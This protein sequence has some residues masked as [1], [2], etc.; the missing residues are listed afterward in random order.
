MIRSGAQHGRLDPRSAD[1]YGSRAVAE[2]LADR[3]VSTRVVTTLD[4]ARSRGRPRHHPPGRRPG[5]AD[6]PPADPPARGDRELRRPHRPR[7]PRRPRPSS[8][9]APGV[10][11]DPALSLDSTLAPG[12][13]LPAARRAGSADTG[14]IR[15]TTA[16]LRR[17]HVLPQRTACPPCVRVPA[18]VRERRHRRPRRPRHPP[19]RPPRRA[20]QRLPRPPTPRLPPPSGLVP[21]LARPTTRPPTPG[22]RS[23]FDLLPS[24]W[25]WGTLQLFIAAALAALW[26]ARRLGPLVPED[27]PWRSA[28]PKPSKAAPAST[29]RPTP[30]TARPPLFAP[31]PAPASPP[32]SASP[33]PRRTR[34]RPC[35][36]P[37]PPTSHGDGQALHAL[38]FGPPPGDDAALIALADQLDALE[39][40]V[41]R[42]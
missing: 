35:S 22:D 33:S 23:F 36:P 9:L 24:G 42:P 31:P 12:C 37:C 11:A 34:P 10:T 20:G 29:A 25:L 2:L 7:R 19:Q 14:G 6:A 27:S 4:E 16:R 40:E 3:G 15:Y 1:P 5:P 21:P 8:T 32:S 28:P 13:D 38:L 18:A 30:A 41:R 17:R 26:R 39:R